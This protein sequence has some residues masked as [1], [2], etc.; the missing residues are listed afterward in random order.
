M[1]TRQNLRRIGE[2]KKI[3][4]AILNLRRCVVEQKKLGY[5][6]QPQNRR[7]HQENRLGKRFIEQ[8]ARGV[9]CNSN[10]LFGTYAIR[11][12]HDDKLVS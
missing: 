5:L 9:A 1:E 11:F 3:K 12:S 6:L 4:Y 10:L 2:L 7:R 8:F